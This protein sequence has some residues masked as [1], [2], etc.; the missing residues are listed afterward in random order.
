MTITSVDL[1]RSRS[2]KVNTTQSTY[3]LVYQVQSDDIADGP[4]TVRNAVGWNIG[5]TYALGA[6]VD[7]LARCI[8]KSATP[9]SAD[10]LTWEVTVSFGPWGS[11]A[12]DTSPL[13]VPWDYNWSQQIV[14]EEVVISVNGYY[15]LNSA[16]DP[17]ID[18]VTRNAARPI[19]SVVRNEVGFNYQLAIYY[20]NAINLDYFSGAPPGTVQCTGINVQGNLYQDNF[21]YYDRVSYSFMFRPEGWDK[22]ILDS[23]Y[24]EVYGSTKRDITVNGKAINSPALLNG[25]GVAQPPFS[26]PYYKRYQVYQALPFSVFGI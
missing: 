23:G 16:G 10:G 26:T 8:D 5:D 20:V 7:L 24:R 22:V 9:K 15:I 13:S 21:G 2:G 3:T 25:A 1:T 17:H 19:L 14:E 12:A 11:D 4:V 6:E 18:T